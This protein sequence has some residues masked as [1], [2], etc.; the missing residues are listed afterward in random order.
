MTILTTDRFKMVLAGL[1]EH[2]P[3]VVPVRVRRCAIPPRSRAVADCTLHNT[4]G[5]PKNFTIR[6][7]DKLPLVAQVDALIHE[8]AH[9]LSLTTQHPSF[10]DH[11][12]E[13]GLAMARCYHVV[14]ASRPTRRAR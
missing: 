4:D 13:W 11:G 6:V 2:C 9:A 7:S 1:R 8:W 10:L 5:R 12:P 3:T 14:D